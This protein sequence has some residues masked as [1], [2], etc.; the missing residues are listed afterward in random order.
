MDNE[1]NK[2]TKGF[3][4]FSL[5]SFGQGIFGRKDASYFVKKEKKIPLEA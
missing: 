2:K 5:D 1:Q 3:G 4:F